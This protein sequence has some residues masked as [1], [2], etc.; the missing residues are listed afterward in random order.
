[1]AHRSEKN[2]QAG[3]SSKWIYGIPR[4]RQELGAFFEVSELD[5]GRRFCSR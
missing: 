1:M 4:L 2:Q 5:C 3:G